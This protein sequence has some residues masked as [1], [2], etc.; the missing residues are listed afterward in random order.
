MSDET[1]NAIIGSVFLKVLQL[2]LTGILTTRTV[3]YSFPRFV[4]QLSLQ[5]FSLELPVIAFVLH[6][7]SMCCKD[8]S[9]FSCC[10]Q[11]HLGL[12]STKRFRQNFVLE[13]VP[14]RFEDKNRVSSNSRNLG[15]SYILS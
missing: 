11:R 13:N 9:F 1:V 8:L 12:V 6:K 2:T 15:S 4:V 10:P 5:P 14:G 3:F 7:K